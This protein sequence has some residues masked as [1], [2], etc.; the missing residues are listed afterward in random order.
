MKKLFLLTTIALFGLKTFAIKGRYS[1]GLFA[2]VGSTNYTKDHNI[3]ESGNVRVW[4]EA[5]SGVTIFSEFEKIYNTNGAVVSNSFV[6]Y[7][8]YSANLST[9]TTP[10][11]VSSTGVR[12]TAS[13]ARILAERTFE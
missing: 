9:Y 6:A 3:H 4:A 12:G 11:Y 2:I 10:S 7:T 13:Q 5:F 8:S 1:S